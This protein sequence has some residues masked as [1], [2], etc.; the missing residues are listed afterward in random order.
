MLGAAAHQQCQNL[1]RSY[2]SSRSVDGRSLSKLNSAM[3][4][5]AVRQQAPRCSRSV[6]CRASVSPAAL[7]PAAG[8]KHVRQLILLRHADSEV[9]PSVRDHDRQLS[10]KGKRWVR[11]MHAARAKRW[12]GAGG[13]G[14]QLPHG[15]G[16]PAHASS[17]RVRVGGR[18]GGML[19]V[20]A[21]RFRRALSGG[22]PYRHGTIDV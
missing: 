18:M 14:L 3:R 6:S 21:R 2:F 22:V 5:A 9:N 17:G 20:S 8:T 10:A 19:P 13:T 7:S 15:R 1:Y 12:V 11:G 4:V 16:W